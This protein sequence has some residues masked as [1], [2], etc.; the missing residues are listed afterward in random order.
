MFGCGPSVEN[1]NGE[2]LCKPGEEEYERLQLA[3]EEAQVNGMP[4]A[5]FRDYIN[6]M[7]RERSEF[8]PFDVNPGRQVLPDEELL[9]RQIRFDPNAP[10]VQV[11]RI[12]IGVQRE[13]WGVPLLRSR[14]ASAPLPDA[15]GR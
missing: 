2:C 1:G 14:A 11:R 9:R 5:A 12:Q 4:A 8:W 10:E 6:D 15:A 13:G 3:V 7:R